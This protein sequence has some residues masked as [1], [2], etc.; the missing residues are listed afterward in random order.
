LLTLLLPVIRAWT[1]AAVCGAIAVSDIPREKL[2]L[3]L[4][5]PGC[6]PWGD[7]LEALGFDVT[8]HATGNDYPSDDR[9][10]R[11]P[12][13]RE[14]RRLSQTLVPGGP[15]LCIEDDV[16]VCPDIYTRLSALGPHATGVVVDRG[17]GKTP[18]IYPLRSRMGKGI[19]GVEGCGY[20]CLLTT[21]EAYRSAVLGNG[22][23]PAD[24][25]HTAQ[26]RPLRVDWGCICGHLT[27]KGELRP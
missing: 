17:R 6:E 13:W 24:I 3:I 19:E 7:S 2:L 14:M 26:L 18:V 25:E 10:E 4:D 12:R 27:E 5:A 1:R 23:G 21:G 20:N 15:L 16:I 11:R 8:T 22:P 9:I